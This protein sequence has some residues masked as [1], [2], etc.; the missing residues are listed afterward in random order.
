MTI[1]ARKQPSTKMPMHEEAKNQTFSR[2]FVSLRTSSISSLPLSLCCRLLW[3]HMK[4]AKQGWLSFAGSTM[5]T[6]LFGFVI[7][8]DGNGGG[9][10]DRMKSGGGPA[11]WSQLPT[12]FPNIKFILWPVKVFSIKIFLYLELYGDKLVIMQSIFNEFPVLGIL[13]ISL[14]A[15]WW[16]FHHNQALYSWAQAP[17]AHRLLPLGPGIIWSCFSSI[18]ADS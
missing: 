16:G 11:S 15:C 18:F 12:Q 6:T 4:A 14:F 8:N 17:H 3:P 13:V 10:I 2:L 7:R 9:G 1:S 5:S